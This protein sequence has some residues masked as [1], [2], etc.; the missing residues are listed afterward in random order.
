MKQLLKHTTCLLFMTGFV[1]LAVAHAATRTMLSNN[2]TTMHN[3]TI[4][5]KGNLVILPSE[6][7]KASDFD[8]LTGD[9]IVHHKKLKERLA[10]SHDWIEFDGRH[11]LQKLLEGRGNLE[12]HFMQD[13][14]GAPIEGVALR[15]FDPKTRLWTIYWS[16][17]RNC[18]LDVPII[19]SF[20]GKVGYFYGKDNFNGRPILVQFKWDASDS[21]QPVWSQAFSADGGQ[22]WE[23][24]WY[25]YF[26]KAP[27]VDVSA[28][29][30]TN[31]QIGVIELRNYVMKHGK[32]DTFIDYFE[33]NYVTS[34]DTLHAH[35]LGRYRVS[36]KD[37]NFCWIR[38]FENMQVRS[39]FLPAFYHGPVWHQT[40]N[41]A[42][43]MLANNDNVYLLKPMT[44][45][46]DSL[47]AANVVTSTTLK[48]Q[49]GITVVEFY[50]ANS[51]LPH[52]LKLFSRSYQENMK[53][54]GFNNFSI[55]TSEMGFNS[56]LQLPIFQDKNLMVVISFFES[57]AA[58]LA[59]AH[60]LESSLAGD[61][62]ADFD[63][64][65]TTKNVW[66]LHPT[67]KSLQ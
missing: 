66:I 10:G 63:D 9:H 46:G 24:N 35:I 58:Y 25:M 59:A 21:N 51:K 20:E 32:R 61:L 53:A 38:G 6:T 64:T 62:K 39:T 30:Q 12:Q 29:P 11:S 43:S 19:G 55:W 49:K 23:W 48:P 14:N 56:F 5:N 54:S 47:V 41:V 7:S 18:R 22:T 42:N 28:V 8:F 1:Y 33:K 60:K 4:D 36:G 34:Q 45:Q 67:E 27:A 50:I 31:D 37:D 3:A 44:L 13:N 65:I 15:L 2:N 40:R 16:D 17:S 26:A 57:E 52:L